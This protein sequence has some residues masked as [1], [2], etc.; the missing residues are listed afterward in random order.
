MPMRGSLEA[1][2]CGV[3][4]VYWLGIGF[5][6]DRRALPL[7]LNMVQVMRRVWICCGCNLTVACLSQRILG[8]LQIAKACPHR[9]YTA[10]QCEPRKSGGGASLVRS[11]GG[12]T[13]GR[14]C[15]EFGFRGVC[16]APERLPLDFW[17]INEGHG[18]GPMVSRYPVGA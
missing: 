14:I 7:G 17:F 9:C 4:G 15:R 12:W 1:W 10:L 18:T 3:L 2:L 13:S 11:R 8:Q 6:F 16:R 5:G